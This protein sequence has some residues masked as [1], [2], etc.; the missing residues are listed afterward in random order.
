MSFGQ[1]WLVDLHKKWL[2]STEEKDKL[3][4][5]DCYIV[6]YNYTHNSKEYHLFYAWLGK[7]STKV[8][9]NYQQ[10]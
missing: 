6:E 5:A 7:E 2:L 9:Y 4:T 3:C 1:V 10:N 8:Q